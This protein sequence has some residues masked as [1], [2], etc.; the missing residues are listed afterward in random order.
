MRPARAVARLAPVLVLTA[1]AA[2]SDAPRSSGGITVESSA[3]AIRISSPT[4]V[5]TVTRSPYR[6]AFGGSDGRPLAAEAGGGGVFWER[7]G[8]EERLGE[9]LD[10]RVLPDGVA[11][12]VAAGAAGSARVTIR[13]VRERTAEVVIEPPAPETVD[14][15][16]DRWQSPADERIYGL[17][18]RL[19]D[20]PLLA[21]GTVDIPREDVVPVE[22]GGLDRRGERVEMIVTPT[23]SVYGPFFHSSRGY[24]LAVSGTAIGWFDV[25]R[26]HP[27]QL[28]FR[29][30]TGNAPESRVLRF[31]LFHGPGHAQILDEYTALTGRPFVPPDWAF[32]H[33]RWRGEL[34]TGDPVAVDGTP[35]NRDVADDVL[36]YEQLGIPPGVYLFDRPV[37]EGEYGF[38]RWAWDTQRLPNVERML[39]SLNRRGYRLM[40]WS[41]LW[42]CGSGPGDNGSDALALGFLAPGGR[43]TPRCDD[44]LG[45]NFILDPTSAAARDWWRDRV[46]DFFRQHGI[47]GVKLDRGEEHIPSEASDVWADGRSG[48]EVRNDYPTLQAKLHHDAITEAFP[49]DSLVFTRSAYTGTQQWAVVWGGDITGS[50]RFGNG[51]GTDLGLRSA[52]ISQQRAAFLGYPIWGSDTGGYYEFKDRDVFA[53]W[54]EFSAFSGIMEIGGVGAHAPWDMPTEPAYDEEMIAIYRRYTTFRERLQPYLVAAARDAGATGLPLVRP[55]VFDWPDDPAVGDLWDEYL[56]G[57]DLLVAPVW[58]TGERAREVYLPAGSWR[59]LWDESQRFEGPVTVT[60]DAPLDR[61]PVF[62]RGDA[63]A[64]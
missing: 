13:F 48:R 47:R 34:R 64:P 62:V 60:V 7:D 4:T 10:E 50:E 31:H 19:R 43:G 45:N 23:F 6:L 55:L 21:P 9:V 18:E 3:D 44:V 16:G 28:V 14:A 40:M 37:L 26:D 35:I 11:L 33:W 17:T 63:P 15:L 51:P 42:A 61:I 8:S 58:R 49:G 54:I 46:R 53:R 29:F 24:G 12:T 2:C 20:S 27:E 36:M 56:L 30:E 59:G 25:A 41:S 32:L 52:I 57:P 38:A 1:V 22:A 5:V 39:E